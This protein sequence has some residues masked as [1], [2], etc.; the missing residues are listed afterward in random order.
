M[1]TAYEQDFYYDACR[2][3]NSAPVCAGIRL[4]EV[5]GIK[6]ISIL[7]EGNVRVLNVVFYVNGAALMTV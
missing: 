1:E 2:R 5:C 3:H 7:N 4:R 6:P